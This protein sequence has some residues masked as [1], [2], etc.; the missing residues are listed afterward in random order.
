ML[1][2]LYAAAFVLVVPALPTTIWVSL[3]VGCLLALLL[4]FAWATK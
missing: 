3:A 2:V 4:G 1:I